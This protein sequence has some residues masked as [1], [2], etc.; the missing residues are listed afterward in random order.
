VWHP[1]SRVSIV[2][3]LPASS[4]GTTT[5]GSSRAPFIRCTSPRPEREVGPHACR[6]V[7]PGDTSTLGAPAD[8]E[9]G[10]E[11][12]AE[13][14]ANLRGTELD[15]RR[16]EGLL[17][18]RLA[19]V[20][21]RGLHHADGYRCLAAWGRGTQ[22]WSDAEARA[23]RN[24]AH[25]VRVCPQVVS[26]LLR[27]QLGVAQAHTIGRLFRA[28]RVGRFVPLFI[29]DIL[30]AAASFDF[31]DFEEY[32][33]RWKLR[34]DPD[35]PDPAR[36]HR[37][38]QASLRFGEHD[39]QLVVIGPN[40]DGVK[41]K[42]LFEQFEQREFQADWDACVAESGADARPELLRRTAEQ[43][44]YD[45]WVQMIRHVELP[46]DDTDPSLLEPEPGVGRTPAAATAPSPERPADGAV[47]TTVNIVIDLRSFL[48]GA[49]QLFDLP[50][51]RH[52]RSPFGA[53]R[54]ICNTLDG[55]LLSAHDAVL[56]ALYAGF[57]LV[58]TDDSGMPIQ[59]TSRSRLFTGRIRDAVLMLAARCTH[60]G[61]NRPNHQC[62]I[63]HLL[64]WSEGGGTSVHNGGPGCAHHNNWRYTSGARARRRPNGSWAT[65]RADG[66]EIAPPDH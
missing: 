42:A 55:T 15:R 43:R 54:P 34:V 35:G 25:L 56:A 50:V 51:Q 63:D 3:S 14:L 32:L 37:E 36:A 9:C 49:R 57:R 33:K 58:V 44:R 53:D 38:R 46:A 18:R 13:L 40:V 21:A 41:L 10:A 17:V 7:A 65:T 60:P 6:C 52:L 27:G 12:G 5:S 61:C 48:E 45:A 16:A 4:P 30:D 26:R 2:P 47:T 28:P 29:D 11:C 23:R 24:L 31:V 19:E 62:E 59:M 64:P 66:T 39:F 1:L 22:R 20:D 8:V